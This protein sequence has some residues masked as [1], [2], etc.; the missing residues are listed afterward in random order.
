M[1]VCLSVPKDLANRWTD[2]VLLNRVD[3]HMSLEGFKLFWGRVPPP[4]QEKWQKNRNLKK[5]LG[6][7]NVKWRGIV[8][9]KIILETLS[10]KNI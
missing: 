2:R 10:N 5:R 3:S 8:H 4:S 7:F 6:D 1:F 9:K